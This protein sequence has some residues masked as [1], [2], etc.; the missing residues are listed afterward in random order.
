MNLTFSKAAAR[1]YRHLDA[2][3][4]KLVQAELNK[5][6]HGEP[7]NIKKLEG[8]DNTWRLRAGDYRITFE[9]IGSDAEV[10]HIK[11]RREVYR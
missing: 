4:Q 10:L 6:I 5:L 2:W 8:K 7:V 9:R 1:D 11:H 3:T